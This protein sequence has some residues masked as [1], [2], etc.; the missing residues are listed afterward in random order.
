MSFAV[1]ERYH[2][3]KTTRRSTRQSTSWS[4]Y[5]RITGFSRNA[6]PRWCQAQHLQCWIGLIFFDT[7]WVYVTKLDSFFLRNKP[8]NAHK[9]HVFEDL[10]CF[11]LFCT[12]VWSI[13]H[14]RTFIPM[15]NYPNINKVLRCHG[16]VTMI[17]SSCDTQVSVFWLSSFFLCI[18]VSKVLYIVVEYCVLIESMHSPILYQSNNGHST[19]ES[20][21]ANVS[22]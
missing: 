6:H 15:Y 1:L 8:A 3:F 4:V 21:N 9:V 11:V 7:T 14:P 2:L 22:L 17:L 13:C 16:Y 18:S 5:T 10:V 19:A 20:M 12:A